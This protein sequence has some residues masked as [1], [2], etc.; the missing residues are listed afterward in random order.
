MGTGI[1]D[2][3]Q[4]CREAG[5]PEPECAVSDGFTVRIRRKAGEATGEATGEVTGEATG[6]VTGEVIRLLHVLIGEMKRAE[7]QESLQL[8][9]EDYFREAY[10]VP[11]LKTGLIEMTIP[12]KPRSGNQK[13]R[14]TPK[15][16]QV[17]AQ[18]KG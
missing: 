10:L 8:R 18:S 11:A 1:R 15:G 4:K 14:I 6:E 5:L 16:R 2:M 3:I 9:H 12:D 7:L 13:Y 17:L